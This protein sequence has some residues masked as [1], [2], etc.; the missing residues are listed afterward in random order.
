LEKRE[1]PGERERALRGGMRGRL[2]SESSE[3]LRRNLLATS[4]LHTACS[5]RL[6]RRSSELKIFVQIETGSGAHLQS[7]ESN[8]HKKIRM[9][10]AD[11]YSRQ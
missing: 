8:M 6:Y 11:T 4:S 2:K 3:E 10:T 1:K 5:S 7:I 9:Q